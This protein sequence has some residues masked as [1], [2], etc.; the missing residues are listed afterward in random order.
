LNIAT[1]YSI[2]YARNP[3]EFEFFI[4]KAEELEYLE[5]ASTMHYAHC[6]T[7]KDWK[8]I[9]ELRREQSDSR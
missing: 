4:E 1:D 8:R 2:G 3:E 6:L 9:E 7:L 5:S